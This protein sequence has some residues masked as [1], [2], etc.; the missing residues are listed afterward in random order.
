MDLA[1]PP[2]SHGLRDS[3][4]QTTHRSQNLA[5]VDGMPVNRSVWT[6]ARHA[7]GVTPIH[8][9]QVSSSNIRLAARDQSDV[10]ARSCW[11]MTPLSL[12]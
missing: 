4:V 7:H 11:G 1:A 9:F 2:L 10:S 3:H 5:P 8:R 12:P 6:C